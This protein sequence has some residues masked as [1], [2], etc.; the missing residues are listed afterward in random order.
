M[1]A[2]VAMLF[3]ACKK[4]EQTIADNTFIYNGVTYHMTDLLLYGGI[5][6]EL[7][8][9]STELGP[10][11]DAAV[12]FCGHHIY[13]SQLNKTFDLTQ[14]YTEG[15]EDWEELQLFVCGEVVNF[16]FRISEDWWD[17]GINE[18]NY[19]STI[20]KEGTLTIAGDENSQFVYSLKGTLQNDDTVEFRIVLP[21]GWYHWNP[22]Y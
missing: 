13:Q 9:Q 4:D 16:G 15:A 22:E 14:F 3:T 18:T 20:F 7:E 19:Y 12:R 1:L 10:N 5:G 2:A 17:G 21:V 6:G 11:G 8:G